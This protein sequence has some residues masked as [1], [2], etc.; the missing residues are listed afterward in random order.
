MNRSTIALITFFA[1]MI[2][3]LALSYS[4]EKVPAV[5]GNH[6]TSWSN[7]SYDTQYYS[8]GDGTQ[9]VVDIPTNCQFHP[10]WIEIGQTVLEGSWK[11]DHCFIT[12][13]DSLVITKSHIDWYIRGELEMNFRN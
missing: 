13:S 8:N 6:P 2:T 4:K 7:V 9:D 12:A 5:A 11:N 10:T 1:V 3:V